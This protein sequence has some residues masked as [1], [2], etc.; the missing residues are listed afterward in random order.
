M[1]GYWYLNLMTKEMQFGEVCQSSNSLVTD[2]LN[3]NDDDP[4]IINT[5]FKIKESLEILD[6]TIKNNKFNEISIS[7]NGGKDCLVMLILYLSSLSKH[8]SKEELNNFGELQSIYINYELQFPELIKFIESSTIRYKLNLTSITMNLK[9]G[10]EKYLS[11][12]PQ[13]KSIIVG[14]RRS[15]PFASDLKHI[16]KTDHGWPEFIRIHPV[17]NWH[18]DEI[19][20]FLKTNKIEYCKLYDQG[21]TSLGGINS[22]IPNPN[23][24]LSNGGYLPAYKLLGNDSQERDGRNIKSIEKE[25]RDE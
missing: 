20:C 21:F 2:F 17:I 23:L 15:D 18:Y 8:Y 6:Q 19:W 12:N 14:T 4:L 10:F 1:M 5:Q 3:L 13:I 16:Q 24:K 7:Y 9:D 11:H 25:V 22:T